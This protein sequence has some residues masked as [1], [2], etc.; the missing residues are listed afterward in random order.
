MIRLDDQ[1]IQA[2]VDVNGLPVRLALS[3]FEA[4]DILTFGSPGDCSFVSHVGRCCLPT[5]AMTP[6][7]SE[8]LP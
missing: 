3:P 1:Q 8:S 2:V 6:P 7:G 5:V 4:H